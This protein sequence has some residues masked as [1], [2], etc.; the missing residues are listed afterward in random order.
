MLL[1]A[2]I[3]NDLTDDPVYVYR[4]VP[5]VVPELTF[6]VNALAFGNVDGKSVI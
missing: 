6:N 2:L 3:S 5:S 1:P 4:L